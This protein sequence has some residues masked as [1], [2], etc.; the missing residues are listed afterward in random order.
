MTGAGRVVGLGFRRFR[1]KVFELAL[2]IWALCAAT[3]AGAETRRHALVI[4]N[5]R[6]FVGKTGGSESVPLRFAD[7]DAAA[8]FEFLGDTTRSSELLTVMDDETQRLYP[9]LATLA[10][11]PTRAAL[12]SA[13]GRIAARIGEDQAG[14]HRS[15][16]M[17]PSQASGSNSRAGPAVFFESRTAT[18]PAQRPD[19]GRAVSTQLFIPVLRLLRSHRTSRSSVLVGTFRGSADMVPPYAPAASPAM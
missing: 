7:D 10:R 4:G 14:G 8:L 13:I 16:V 19:A 9:K 5:N 18:R 17:N 6:P 12:R 1:A 15:V 2:G 11:V 3:P